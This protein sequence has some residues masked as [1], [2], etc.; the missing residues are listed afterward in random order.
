VATSLETSKQ[1]LL[2]DLLKE[3]S[4]FFYTDVRDQVS[5]RCEGSS[6]RLDQSSRTLP[7]VSCLNDWNIA[8]GFSKHLRRTIETV[9]RSHPCQN[10]LFVRSAHACTKLSLFQ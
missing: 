6:E 9:D 5:L 10:G 8:S 1:E 3:V 2:R 4:R 7:S